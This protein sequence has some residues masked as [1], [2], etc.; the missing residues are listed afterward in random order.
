MASLNCLERCILCIVL[1][2]AMISSSY[3]TLTGPEIMALE[4]LLESFP[5][6]NYI[7]QSK[8]FEHEQWLGGS[9][10]PS[11]N[12]LCDEGPG[13]VYHG[14]HCSS[15]GHIDGIYVY[16]LLLSKIALKRSITLTIIACSNAIH[17]EVRAHG[18]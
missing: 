9:W 4:G 5:S 7:T 14:L 11:F 6:L 17:H 18:V 16:V 2:L 15:T 10:Y 12:N 3:A 1:V 13:Y 8:Q